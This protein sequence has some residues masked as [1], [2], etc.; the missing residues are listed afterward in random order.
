MALH[1]KVSL[2]STNQCW[3]YTTAFHNKTV[4]ITQ[5]RHKMALAL[6]VQRH[7]AS[8]RFYTKVQLWYSYKILTTTVF[9]GANGHLIT[10]NG[11]S[12]IITHS[13]TV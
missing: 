11:L 7:L 4:F 10:I 2:C 5:A 3:R 12:M 13:V 9:S 1:Q 6:R 8:T